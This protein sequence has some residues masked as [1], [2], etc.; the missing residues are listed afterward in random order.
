LLRRG[1][2]VAAHDEKELGKFN[3]AILIS[4]HVVEHV[5]SLVLGHDGCKLLEGLVLGHDGCKLLGGDGAIAIPKTS[6]KY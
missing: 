3:C 4:I 1:L 5:R 2:F 6:V